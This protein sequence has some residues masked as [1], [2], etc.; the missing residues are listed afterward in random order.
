MK[1][2]RQM[3]LLCCALIIK[4]RSKQNTFFF[5]TEHYIKK[6]PDAWCIEMSSKYWK[7]QRQT[8]CAFCGA[9]PLSN[10][11]TIH[12][13]FLEAQALQTRAEF[14]K[15][16]SFRI[17]QNKTWRRP[18]LAFVSQLRQI[19]LVWSEHI[20]FNNITQGSSVR[21]VRVISFAFL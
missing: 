9:E 6:H 15:K 3:G 11:K 10:L 5:T 20:H 2:I 14:M 21:S 16:G 12:L 17:S 8:F 18:E 13:D 1:W 7:H 19:F 4:D